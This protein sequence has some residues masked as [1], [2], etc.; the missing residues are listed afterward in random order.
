MQRVSGV[1]VDVCAPCDLDRHTVEKQPEHE[2]L[3]VVI[4]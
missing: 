3:D 4:P 1:V 2:S